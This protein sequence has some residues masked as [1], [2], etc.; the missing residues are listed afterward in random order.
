M[1]KILSIL[2]AVSVTF[3]ACQ[4][5]A[6]TMANKMHYG[7]PIQSSKTAGVSDHGPIIITNRSYQYANVSAHFIDGSSNTMT[8]YPRGHYPRNVISI[9]DPYP[10]VDIEITATDGS[11]LFPD[12]AVYPGQNVVI[13]PANQGKIKP[14]VSI[15]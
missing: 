7:T 12:Q 2:T 4:A 3:F 8:I 14:S 13:N 11:V 5:M 9:E 6:N 15:S 10:Y 1:K